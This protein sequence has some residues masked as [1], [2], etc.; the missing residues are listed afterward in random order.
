VKKH[1]LHFSLLISLVLSSGYSSH[2]WAVVVPLQNINKLTVQEEATAYHLSNAKVFIA[3][4]ALIRRDFAPLVKD[5]TDVEI[6]QWLV[7]NASLIAKTQYDKAPGAG[8]CEEIPVNTSEPVTVFRPVDYGRGFVFRVGKNG[9]KDLLIDTKGVGAIEPTGESYHS[10]GFG[11]LA[12]MILEFAFEKLVHQIFIHSHSG[13]DTIETYAVIDPG[14]RACKFKTWPDAGIVLR[15]AHVRYQANDVETPDG[16]MHYFQLDESVAL[17]ME[18]V[19]RPYGMT[20]TGMGY[21]N[22][23]G[24]RNPVYRAHDI[25]G[26]VEGALVDF[27]PFMVNRQFDGSLVK[28]RPNRDGSSDITLDINGPHFIQ[29][30]PAIM[31]SMKDWSIEKDETGRLVHRADQWAR[32]WIREVKGGWKTER[33][34]AN[35]LNQLLLNE[36]NH[37]RKHDALAPLTSLPPPAPL[38]V[39]TSC[40]SPHGIKSEITPDGRSVTLSWELP[41]D[42]Q[43]ILNYQV[44]D[45]QDKMIWQGPATSFTDSTLPGTPGSFSYNIYSQCASG[46]SQSLNYTVVV[47]SED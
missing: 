42:S 34:F 17:A 11:E 32:L 22:S 13:F 47:Q 20:S 35:F 7:K 36:V 21:M 5:L 16:Y 40:I 28:V 14:F 15:Q 4:Y 30:D 46:L 19:M 12:E 8:L 2:V 45:W 27:G 43:T 3:D 31:V 33:D 38:P 26:S 25:Q 23:V 37:W 44:K 24:K 41:Q 1:L 6:D 9:T 18:K 39:P 29:P 10:D